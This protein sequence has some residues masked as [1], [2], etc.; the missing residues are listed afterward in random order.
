MHSRKIEA[1]RQGFS[2]IYADVPSYTRKC[3]I[4]CKGSKKCQAGTGKFQWWQ[5]II[6]A[7]TYIFS[8]K[9]TRE[10]YGA[11]LRATCS[12]ALHDSIN[13]AEGL[14][15]VKICIHFEVGSAR[16]FLVDVKMRGILKKKEK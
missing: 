14:G 7:T 10:I 2:I 4:T 3:I 11:S 6:P 16:N 8:Q 9:H 13:V 15:R 5:V 12:E 1:G